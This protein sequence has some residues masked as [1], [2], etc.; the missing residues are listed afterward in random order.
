MSKL[1]LADVVKGIRDLPSLPSVV[2]ELLNSFE[3][4]DASTSAL[5]NKVSQDQAL[6]AKTLRLANS[7]FYGLQ[8]KVT[9]I[10]QAITVL[11]F[12]NVRTLVMA[13]GV[14]SN[15]SSSVQEDFNLANFWQHAVG[16][17]LCA[18]ALARALNLSQD[19]AFISGLLHDIGR[20]VLVSQ[21]PDQYAKIIAYRTEH[22]CTMLEAERSVVV[23][24]HTIIGQALAAYWKFPIVIQ[25]SIENHHA[26]M[27]QDL[28]GIPSVIHIADAI[29]YALDLTGSE[30]DLVPVISD[31]AWHSLNLSPAMLRAVFR[32]TEAEFEE[33][34]KILGT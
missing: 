9:T 32:Q 3:Q 14:I 33:V 30:D 19:H 10:Q 34:C 4:T 26:P 22:D 15:F 11:G 24:D 17:A 5:A 28:G 27:L 29:A 7:S 16:T 25:R 6:A 8:H 1:V 2:I 12:D 23:V 18:K 20:L 21:F 31:N 13:A